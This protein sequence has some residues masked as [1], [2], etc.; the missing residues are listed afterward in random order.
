MAAVMAPAMPM[1]SGRRVMCRARFGARPTIARMSS[2]GGS[3]RLARSSSPN[4]ESPLFQ[5]LIQSPPIRVHFDLHPYYR[6]GGL[7]PYR[8]LAR[9][10]SLRRRRLAVEQPAQPAERTVERDLDRVRALAEQLGDLS[11][12]EIGAVPQRDEVPLPR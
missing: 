8:V 11:H 4:F 5:N 2:F 9:C 1:R 7:N 3:G 10:E 12:L 6:S